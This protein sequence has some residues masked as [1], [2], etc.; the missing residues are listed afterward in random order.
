[1]IDYH[2]SAYLRDKTYSEIGNLFDTV[3]TLQCY[4]AVNAGSGSA[5]RL[6]MS[7]LV[8]S[9]RFNQWAYKPECRLAAIDRLQP[10]DS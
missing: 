10:S 3:T 7:S 8:A 9:S 2:N 4:T 6:Q 1:M 5:G